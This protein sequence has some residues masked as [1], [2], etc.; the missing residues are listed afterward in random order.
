MHIFFRSF[1]T[2]KQFLKL[3]AY[4][5]EFYG[6]LFIKNQAHLMKVYRFRICQK[7]DFLLKRRWF[8][9][10]VNIFGNEK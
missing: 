10:V 3:R 9:A 2:F 5:F 7:I 6:I 8:F 1:K 4:L